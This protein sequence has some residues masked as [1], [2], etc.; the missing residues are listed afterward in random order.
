MQH[1]AA[2]CLRVHQRQW[3]GGCVL[4]EPLPRAAGDRV[5]EQG[6][7]GDALERALLFK[8]LATLRTDAPLFSSVDE[9]EWRGPTDAFPAWAERIADERLLPRAQATAEAARA[10]D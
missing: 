2:Q 3:G 1:A 7:L 9:L 10:T 8:R 5:H 4:A 6:E